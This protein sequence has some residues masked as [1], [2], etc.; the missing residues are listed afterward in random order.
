MIIN[1]NITSHF[2]TYRL[3][4]G[5]PLRSFTALSFHNGAGTSVVRY[6]SI[7][8]ERSLGKKDQSKSHALCAL[9][10]RYNFN[11]FSFFFS[12]FF[13]QGEQER[14]INYST[15]QTSSFSP[16]EDTGGPS[17]DGESATRTR[18]KKLGDLSH[19]V[20]VYE[21]L[22][23]EKCIKESRQTR[24]TRWRKTIYDD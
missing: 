7:K 12:C 22:N 24:Q 16:R 10:T 13:F 18:E 9:S 8:R 3:N 6:P 14:E 1:F 5:F 17:L 20:N 19:C 15:R 4:F 21:N 2:N 23:A 11:F